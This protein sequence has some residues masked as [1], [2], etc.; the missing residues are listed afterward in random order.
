MTDYQKRREKEEEGERVIRV[1]I[2]S[3]PWNYAVE[4][5]V[6]WESEEEWIDNQNLRQLNKQKQNKPLLHSLRF[7]C[8]LL[9]YFREIGIKK[10]SMGCLGLRTLHLSS[11][12]NTC[13]VFGKQIELYITTL[14]ARSYHSKLNST[15]FWFLCKVFINYVQLI[16]FLYLS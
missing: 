6:C 5:F 13:S 7:S 9:S 16:I 1:G 2:F 4:A 12:S 15:I 8:V 11:S 10:R 3:W 14:L